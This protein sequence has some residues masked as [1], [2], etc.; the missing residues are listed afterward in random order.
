ML[1]PCVHVDRNVLGYAYFTRE[2]LQHTVTDNS[3]PDLEG[4]I[5]GFPYYDIGV[6]AIVVRIRHKINA[7]RGNRSGHVG[8]VLN[9][10]PFN[11]NVYTLIR[12]DV[13]H[14]GIR[15]FGVRLFGRRV[16]RHVFGARRQR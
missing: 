12:S 2:H 7:F 16:D 3:R 4:L 10:I 9:F 5:F 6:V 14:D 13:R 11:G 1:R 15:G 8:F